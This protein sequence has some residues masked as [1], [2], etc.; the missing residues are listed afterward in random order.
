MKTPAK[1]KAAKTRTSATR[2]QRPVK[3]LAARKAPA[4]GTLGDGSVRFVKETGSRRPS[5]TRVS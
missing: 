5:G 4:G 2:R 3:D 1:N